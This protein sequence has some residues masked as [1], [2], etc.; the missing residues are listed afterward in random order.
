[1]PAI[2]DEKSLEQKLT[3]LEAARIWSPRVV[4]KLEAL[5]RGDDEFALFKVNPLRF[6]AQKGIAEAEAI[7][8]FLHAAKLGLFHMSWQLVCPHCGDTVRSF[9]SLRGLRTRL[10]CSFCHVDTLAQ[11]DEYI[12]V[13]FTVAAP[14]RAIAPHHP[15][16]LSPEDYH[17]RYRF[18]EGARLPGGGPRFTEV[19][20][21]V[22]RH[23]SFLEPG[24]SRTVE[25]ELG[26]GCLYAHDFVRETGALFMVKGAAHAGRKE[27]SVRTGADFAPNA[28]DLT[29]G[30]YALEF[31]NPGQSRGSLML[32]NFPPAE[33]H[34]DSRL[35]FDPFLSGKRLLTTQTFRDLF[36]S[37]AAVG[38]EGI[39][40]KDLT[41][42]F[43]DLKG[44]TALY[45]RIGDLKAYALVQ[46]HFE[47]LGRAV[48]G[49]R[50]AI[51]KTIG[52]AVMASF[53]DPADAV[54]AALLMLEEIDLFNA[55]QGARDIILKIGIHKGPL[56]AVNLN[57]RLDY[58]GQ[59]VNI[60]ARVQ[61]LADADQVCVTEEVYS[62]PGVPELLRGLDAAPEG[63][64]LKGVAREMRVRRMLHKPARA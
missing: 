45:D 20:R 10:C 39:G 24:R 55:E 56:I 35:V 64:R 30:A 6:A 27:L 19:L 53:L 15:E 46:Q 63:A 42:L 7:D 51:V 17:L 37:D 21:Q 58:F 54:A 36:R 50:G 38:S 32:A 1:M 28:G 5:L 25:V 22:I 52:D 43:T 60:A 41:L 48:R 57:E 16:K 44:S 61:G 29:P 59:T 47:R 26:P 3:G 12:E 18:C 33:E 49:H 4:S 2:L 40:V 13:A 34:C 9:T 62:F 14:V 11:L 23:M 8:L 31:H